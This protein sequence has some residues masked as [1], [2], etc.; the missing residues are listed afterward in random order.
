MTKNQTNTI[1]VIVIAAIIALIFSLVFSRVFSSSV[2]GPRGLPG[3][4]GIPGPAGIQGDTGPQGPPGPPGP[5]VTWG[6]LSGKP[7]FSTVALSGNYQDLS[8]KPTLSNVALSGNYQDLSGA[9]LIFNIRGDM[10]V[11]NEVGLITTLFDVHTS[12]YTLPIGPCNGTYTVNGNLWCRIVDPTIPYTQIVLL[13]LSSYNGGNINN[14]LINITVKE[15]SHPDTP[16]RY[17]FLP[18]VQNTSI[19]PNVGIIEVRIALF[20]SDPYLTDISLVNNFFTGYLI[21][22]SVF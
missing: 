18:Y 17:R 5:T 20:Y 16:T 19:N 4:P 6:T 21:I 13:E 11:I 1:L 14:Q 8:N 9:P 3:F 10:P 22:S 15:S 2:V 12:Q 7:N